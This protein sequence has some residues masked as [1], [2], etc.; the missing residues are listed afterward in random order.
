[1]IHPGKDGFYG[2]LDI[3]K[4]DPDSY[5]VQAMAFN[6][7]FDHPIMAM[8][9]STVSV[10]ATEP[11]CGG[12]VRLDINLENSRHLNLH[13]AGCASRMRVA[14]YSLLGSVKE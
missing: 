13:D 6:V 10:V 2:R 7:Y 11:M 3:A 12:K 4:I 14:I 5:F 1:V 9:A 8:N